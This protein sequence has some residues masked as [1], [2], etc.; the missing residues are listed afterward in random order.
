MHS[1][2]QLDR[3]FQYAFQTKHRIKPLK[4]T[5]RI[6]EVTA[7]ASLLKQEQESGNKINPPISAAAPERELSNHR[8]IHYARPAALFHL[9]VLREVG[10]APARLPFSPPPSKPDRG[11]GG[12]C[13]W[14][15]KDRVRS[16]R[17][18]GADWGEHKDKNGSGN[19]RERS[20]ETDDTT[21]PSWLAA[22]PYHIDD[23]HSL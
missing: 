14:M 23:I 15:L 22:P 18:S 7:E 16:G 11:D 21:L 4:K 10:E 2:F 17:G 13:Q 8:V 20:W 1:M 19:W 3:S 6:W 12:R 9:H 5:A